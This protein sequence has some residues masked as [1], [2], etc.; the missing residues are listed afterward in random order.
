MRGSGQRMHFVG[1]KRIFVGKKNCII[2]VTSLVTATHWHPGSGRRG[3]SDGPGSRGPDS[4]A[5]SQWKSWSLWHWQQPPA[6]AAGFRPQAEHR[7]PGGRAAADS[8]GVQPLSHPCASA[9]GLVQPRSPGGPTAKPASQPVA[10]AAA[11][12]WR[13]PWHT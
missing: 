9:E 11:P 6:Q 12:R 7:R 13:R 3:G 1:K 5:P 8:H 4:E 10:R 2:R